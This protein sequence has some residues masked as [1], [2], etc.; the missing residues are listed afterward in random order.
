M[1]TGAG[2]LPFGARK[3]RLREVMA[4]FPAAYQLLPAVKPYG[5]EL[6]P[7]VARPTAVA[8]DNGRVYALIAIPIPGAP[9][10]YS[11]YG[12]LALNVSVDVR[13][14]VGARVE[15][16]CLASSAL[17]AA[18]SARSPVPGHPLIVGAHPAALAHSFCI[19]Y[20]ASMGAS[21]GGFRARYLVPA[22]LVPEEAAASYLVVAVVDATSACRGCEDLVRAVAEAYRRVQGY[23]ERGAR[24]EAELEA[25]RVHRLVL[26]ALGGVNVRVEVASLGVWDAYAAVGVLAAVGAAVLAYTGYAVGT[27]TAT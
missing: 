6:E 11:S 7:R 8:L 15:H 25:R 4:T 10:P 24:P 1:L 3:T 21:D 17:L 14:G 9:H 16:V 12:W 20:P 23:L 19:A 27:V 26:G 5:Y 18:L 22:S 2:L 13:T